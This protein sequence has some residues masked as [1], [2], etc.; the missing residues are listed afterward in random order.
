V[1]HVKRG[2]VASG[3]SE[4]GSAD[5]H[6]ALIDRLEAAYLTA[7]ELGFLGPREGAR[8]RE[9]HIE[10][11]LALAEIR[12]PRP[13]ERWAD[14]GSGAGLPGL[15]LAACFPETFFTLIDAHQRRLA[16]VATAAAELG[17]DNVATVHGRLEDFGHGADRERF[18]VATARA[19]GSLP[20]VA[21]LG[22]PLVRV[23]GTLIVPRGRPDDAELHEARLACGLLGGDVAEVVPNPASPIDPV[24]FVVIMT[25][26]ASTSPRFPR[27][28]GVPTRNPL[29]R[30]RPKRR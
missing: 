12:A 30:P 24:G 3:A 29:G 27:R 15:P 23:G 5:S 14:L 8:L 2:P 1:F 20:V 22:L 28:S 11:A 26:T 18:D 25:K 9:R 10:D 19:L 13:G 16:W 17:L 4:P 6:Q 21:E 7:I